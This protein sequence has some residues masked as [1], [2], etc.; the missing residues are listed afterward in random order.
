[1]NAAYKSEIRAT[2]G[3]QIILCCYNFWDAQ[4]G[5][6]SPGNFVHDGG[7]YT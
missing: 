6:I 3:T 5:E 1:M 4:S 7:K 2:D